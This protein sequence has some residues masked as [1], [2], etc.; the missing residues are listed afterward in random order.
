[1]CVG[2]GKAKEGDRIEQE[3]I[4]VF[5]VWY[6]R[7]PKGAQVPPLGPGGT[8]RRTREGE[9][10]E[11]RINRRESGGKEDNMLIA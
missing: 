5:I 11:M 7:M 6:L 3:D 1:M 10:M 8:A 2:Q 9:E 4:Y